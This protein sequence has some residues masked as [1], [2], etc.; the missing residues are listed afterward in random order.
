M[1]YGMPSM[2]NI[3]WGDV[4][5]SLLGI[6][7]HFAGADA[8]GVNGAQANLDWINKI[9]DIYK[10]YLGPYQDAGT[11]ALGTYQNQ[12]DSLLKDPMGF[13]NNINAGFQKSPY[14][15]FL[16]NEMTNASNNAAAAG[17][18]LGTGSHQ[19][20]L[21]KLIN[22]LASG[23]QQQY[24]NNVMQPFNSA[25]SGQQFLTGQGYNAG[26]DI[27]QG[28]GGAYQ[29]AGNLAGQQAMA[30]AGRT[31]GLLG[32]VGGLLGGLGG[33]GSVVSGVGSLLGG[34]F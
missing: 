10:Q 7:G 26:R 6:G 17:G 29:Q 33:I 31:G 18:T 5:N 8:G 24:F 25:L 22:G 21:A 4:G 14:Y 19:Y 11:K 1:S 15:N 27:A 2:P 13:V 28:I 34:L 30:Q 20:E 16:T 9:P 12:L 23:E 32:G 3:N